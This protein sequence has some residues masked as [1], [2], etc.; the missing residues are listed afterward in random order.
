[1]LTGRSA[2]PAQRRGRVKGSPMKFRSLA[3]TAALVLAATFGVLA[4]SGVVTQ[5]DVHP[6]CG[7][8]FAQVMSAAGADWLDR[9][10]RIEEEEPDRAL[11]V[12]KI[13]KGAT[14]ADVGAGSGY[15]TVKLSA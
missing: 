10:E 11:D 15:M 12:L 2:R 7:R 9:H 5:S 3:G 13:Q 6:I 4:Q 1:M 14:V 8:R